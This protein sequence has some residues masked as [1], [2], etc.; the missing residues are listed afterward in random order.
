MKFI[1]WP[2]DHSQSLHPKQLGD[3]L[4]TDMGLPGGKKGK[5]GAYATGARILEDLAAAGSAHCRKRF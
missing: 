3:I 4:F 5:S 2:G 1:N